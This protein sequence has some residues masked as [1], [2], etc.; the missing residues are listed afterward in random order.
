[1][2][3]RI[4]STF[5]DIGLTESARI[6]RET[7]AGKGIQGIHTSRSIQARIGRALV[8]IGLAESA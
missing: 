3:T 5:V 6:T 2:L 4:G 7:G 8:D 1:M